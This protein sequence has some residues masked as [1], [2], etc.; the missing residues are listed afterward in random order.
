METFL[1][2]SV[3]GFLLFFCPMLLLLI[4][5]RAKYRRK[6]FWVAIF[7]SL[8]MEFSYILSYIS[9]DFIGL[10]LGTVILLSFIFFL[11]VLFSLAENRKQVLCII[12][13][14]LS[15]YLSVIITQ[16]ISN[17]LFG[18][19]VWGIW[20]GFMQTFIVCIPLVFSAWLIFV[21]VRKTTKNEI[22]PFLSIGLVIL[23]VFPYFLF[24]G[25]RGTLSWQV[26]MAKRMGYNDVKLWYRHEKESMCRKNLQDMRKVVKNYYW[27]NGV[28]PS[29]IND[30]IF[31]TYCYEF[32]WENIPEKDNELL[33]KYLEKELE[34]KWVKI[35][36]IKKNN[37]NQMIN[38]T[39][40][41]N[42]IMLK[43][44]KEY[45]HVNIEKLKSGVTSG[46]YIA[47]KGGK[48]RV[49]ATYN[50]VPSALLSDHTNTKKS[51]LSEPNP[52][53]ESNHLKL[54]M[55]EAGFIALIVE[56]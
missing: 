53:K 49:G 20:K 44:N 19:E 48:L 8:L 3:G 42:L 14:V 7:F 23:Y 6:L 41:E 2:I 29:S 31:S 25:G 37:D 35:P 52:T 15:V 46:E 13:G 17:K 10:N 12:L 21:L 43:L 51:L 56:I 28:Y 26:K 33:I 32:I 27:E 1:L 30:E 54:Q 55:K 9:Q 50:E 39:D 45:N 40:G 18:E 16:F 38:V 24:L 4:I 5:A 36:R 22:L 34:I 47:K 11:L